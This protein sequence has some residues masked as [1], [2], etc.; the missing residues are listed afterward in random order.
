MWSSQ[1]IEHKLQ[2]KIVTVVCEENAYEVK[3]GEDGSISKSGIPR[4]QSNQ[5]DTYIGIVLY[6]SYTAEEQYK[7]V[8]V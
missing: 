1:N 3:L 5:E 4:P 2:R 6:C 8:G 7:Y